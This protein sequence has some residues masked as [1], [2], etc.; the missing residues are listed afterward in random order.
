MHIKFNGFA[1]QGCRRGVGHLLP[2]SSWRTSRRGCFAEIGTNA[3]LAARRRP[4]C[5]HT[6]R[7]SPPGPRRPPSYGSA[8][9]PQQINMVAATGPSA[10]LS[11]A[12]LTAMYCVRP[13]IATPFGV[14]L[15]GRPR[16]GQER[17]SQLALAGGVSFRAVCRR[18]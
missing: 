14:A 13:G 8:A 3:P 5:N 4:S 17:R 2:C 10:E 12:P 15:P 11:A 6:A 16:R 18:S 9:G 7:L 1:L